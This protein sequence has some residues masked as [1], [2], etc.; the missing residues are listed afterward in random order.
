MI[1]LSKEVDR[2][3]MFSGHIISVAEKNEIELGD[4]VGSIVGIIM[5]L[6]LIGFFPGTPEQAHQVLHG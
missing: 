3:G 5:G 1:I 4:R 6:I 2:E